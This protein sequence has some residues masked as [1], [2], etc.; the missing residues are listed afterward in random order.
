M[1]IQW[2]IEPTISNLGMS[3]RLWETY[4]DRLLNFWCKDSFLGRMFA[5]IVCIISIFS[6]LST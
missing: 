4:E 5:A 3:E 1:G 6:Q 2:D